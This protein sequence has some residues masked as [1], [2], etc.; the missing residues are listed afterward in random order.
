M[1]NVLRLL[2]RSMS[3]CLVFDI[4]NLRDVD[5]RQRSINCSILSVL[6]GWLDEHPLA[7]AANGKLQLSP[8]RYCRRAPAACLCP[9]FLPNDSP[10]PAEV[11]HPLNTLKLHMRNDHIHPINAKAPD[12]LNTFC[13][14]NV[15]IK[16]N[17]LCAHGAVRC[18]QCVIKTDLQVAAFEQ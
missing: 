9:C 12:P 14:S 13:S 2:H 4:E 1:L 18:A 3:P 10:S 17:S 15:S 5:L 6:Q 7:A 16:L 8:Q 11:P